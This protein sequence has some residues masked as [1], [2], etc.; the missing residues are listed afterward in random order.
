ML[1]AGEGLRPVVLILIFLQRICFPAWAAS[2]TACTCRAMNPFC[3]SASTTFDVGIPL[4]HT[5]IELPMHSIWYLFHWLFLK[6][7]L[8]AGLSSSEYNQPRRASSY[9]PPL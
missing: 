5:L 7:F 1:S 4:S 2:F 8:P 3:V 6:A 9:N